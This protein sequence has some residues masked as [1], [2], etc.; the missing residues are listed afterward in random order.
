MCSDSVFA[1]YMQT[2]SAMHTNTEERI[3]RTADVL[4]SF[5][6]AI[7]TDRASTQAMNDTIVW[8]DVSA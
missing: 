3:T 6:A 1:Q 5:S 4:S 7:D 2:V 8:D